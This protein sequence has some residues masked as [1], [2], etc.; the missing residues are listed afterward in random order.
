MIHNTRANVP[1]EN[2]YTIAPMPDPLTWWE[3]DR[4]DYAV[5]RLAQPWLAHEG[6]LWAMIEIENIGDDALGID[7]MPDDDDGLWLAFSTGIGSGKERILDELALRKIARIRFEEGIIQV[8][9]GPGQRWR[10]HGEPVELARVQQRASATRYSLTA[11]LSGAIT[12]VTE[13]DTH[14]VQFAPPPPISGPIPT[15]DLERRPELPLAIERHSERIHARL[16]DLDLS[17]DRARAGISYVSHHSPTFYCWGFARDDA[18][19]PPALRAGL[20][21]LGDALNRLPEDAITIRV[22]GYTELQSVWVGPGWETLASARASAVIEALGLTRSQEGDDPDTSRTREPPPDP[23][24]GDAWG[25]CVEISLWPTPYEWAMD[26]LR[27]YSVSPGPLLTVLRQNPGVHALLGD[28]RVTCSHLRTLYR[29]RSCVLAWLLA[30]SRICAS[31]I[32]PRWGTL[33]EIVRA[34]G[35]PTPR[36][37]ARMDDL[38]RLVSSFGPTCEAIVRIHGALMGINLDTLTLPSSIDDATRRCIVRLER[39]RAMAP[40][41]R[42][43]ALAS[44]LSSL[45]FDDEL[46]PALVVAIADA[47]LDQDQH[48]VF[49][50]PAW[51]L[52]ERSVADAELDDLLRREDG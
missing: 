3:L 10:L 35:Q 1:R 42:L 21:E 18:E 33:Q 22:C 12:L 24:F 14:L 16:H 38:E 34:H 32:G 11:I 5:V 43:R 25:R 9:L 28:G 46:A 26:L 45:E 6:Q 41:E 17:E 13:A 7:Y 44:M 2:S 15:I 20:A 39:L 51:S 40:D 52:F 23:A 29:E 36:W 8:R 47:R 4:T 27:P 37:S 48:D 50:P 19:V 49:A 31:H 30:P